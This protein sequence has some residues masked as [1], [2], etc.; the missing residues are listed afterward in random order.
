MSVLSAKSAVK[1]HKNIASH[2]HHGLATKCTT[3]DA[4]MQPYSSRQLAAS[5]P[6]QKAQKLIVTDVGDVVHMH[7]RYH[8]S[9]REGKCTHSCRQSS[10]SESAAAMCCWHPSSFEQCTAAAS[11]RFLKA[12]CHYI[13]VVNV[14]KKLNVTSTSNTLCYQR[15]FVLSTSL[16]VQ[17]DAEH[18]RASQE[19]QNGADRL[20]SVEQQ[21]PFRL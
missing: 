5:V 20:K 8:M 12:C 3:L 6:A 16:H 18:M 10:S 2:V 17:H 21:L 9:L 15:L 1:K 13:Q 14:C 19:S 4:A 11:S 7:M